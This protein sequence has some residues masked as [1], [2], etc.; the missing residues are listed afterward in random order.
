MRYAKPIASLAIICL[1][2]FSLGGCGHEKTQGA[3]QSALQA[4]QSEMTETTPETSKSS[5]AQTAEAEKRDE[6]KSEPAPEVKQS[7]AQAAAEEETI[8]NKETT[9]D[10]ETAAQPEAETCTI[11]IS[12]ANLVGN[13][14]KLPEAERALVPDD[15]LL[16]AKTEFEFDDGDS[17]FDVLKRAVKDN[18]IQMEY[19]TSPA[20]NTAYIEGMG[21][22]YEFDAGSAS[23]WCY[24]VNG[25]MPNVGCSSYSLS[26]GDDIVFEYTLDLG[27]DT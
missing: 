4:S 22:L 1:L 26:D 25:D 10:K 18:G 5:T 7:K 16:L 14:D 24:A 23:G 12:C 15:G 8:T 6:K 17:V 20:Y 11:T 2:L 13:T 27:E 9:T 3:S 21:N 19:S